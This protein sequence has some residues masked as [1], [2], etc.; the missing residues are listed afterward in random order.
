MKYTPKKPRNEK[1]IPE[2]CIKFLTVIGYFIRHWV[3]ASN[4]SHALFLTAL[5][6]PC[7][8]LH[9]PKSS[10]SPAI[11]LN[12]EISVNLQGREANRLGALRVIMSRHC[13]F[14]YRIWGYHLPQ[15]TTLGGL[16]EKV[17][18]PSPALSPHLRDCT[19]NRHVCMCAFLGSGT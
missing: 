14:S 13:F 2:L 5:H 16:K 4:V 6:M 3:K 17:L 19:V 15:S 10:L 9:M 7:S 8:F 12:R 18:D 1:D 11:L